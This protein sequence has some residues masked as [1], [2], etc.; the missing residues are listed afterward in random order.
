MSAPVPAL[1]IAGGRYSLGRRVGRGSFGEIFQGTEV[2]TREAVAIKLVRS[3]EPQHSTMSIVADGS[4][5][6]HH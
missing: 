5:G 1:R 3:W 2:A 4:A 6:T